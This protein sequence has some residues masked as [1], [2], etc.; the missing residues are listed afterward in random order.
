[1][2][3]ADWLG[4]EISATDLHT[5]IFLKACHLFWCCFTILLGCAPSYILPHGTCCLFPL[6][7]ER[8]VMGTR[9]KSV[10]VDR[11]RRRGEGEAGRGG[12]GGALLEI[13]EGSKL[14]QTRRIYSPIPFYPHNSP[15]V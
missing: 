12:G 9:F 8:A 10:G 13:L 6:E 14:D 15:R 3:W 7:I 2:G 5:R 1:M 11:W 4:E